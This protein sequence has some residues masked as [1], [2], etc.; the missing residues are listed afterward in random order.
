MSAASLN[1]W[2]CGHLTDDAT[3]VSDAKATPADGDIG[4]C[5]YCRAVQVFTGD[6]FEHRAP[7]LTELDRIDSDPRV[8]VGMTI[9]SRLAA[10]LR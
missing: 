4:V 7:T 6:G 1:C 5:L 3:C 2:A 8:P 9:A 10:M